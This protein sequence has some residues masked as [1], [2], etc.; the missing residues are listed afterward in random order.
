MDQ[1]SGIVFVVVAIAL[2]IAFSQL[3]NRRGR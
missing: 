3:T 1:V 2:I